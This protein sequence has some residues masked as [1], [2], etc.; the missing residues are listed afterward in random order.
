M[1]MKRKAAERTVKTLSHLRSFRLQPPAI[2]FPFSRWGWWE[3]GIWRFNRL[4]KS[5]IKLGHH[6]SLEGGECL[7]TWVASR[8]WKYLGDLVE[9]KEGMA[10]EGWALTITRAFWDIHVSRVWGQKGKRSNGLLNN[11]AV[12]HFLLDFITVFTLPS[13]SPLTS[14]MRRHLTR[15]AVEDYTNSIYPTIAS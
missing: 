12:D 15:L 8:W 14:Q 1:G 3:K 7:S 2:V 10:A 9:V 13:C 11:L 6:F 4:N 5:K